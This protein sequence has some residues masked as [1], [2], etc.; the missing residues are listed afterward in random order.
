MSDNDFDIKRIIAN[1]KEEPYNKEYNLQDNV[2]LDEFQNPSIV[3][4]KGFE[5]LKSE[6][7]PYVSTGYPKQ[8]RDSFFDSKVLGIPFM[9]HNRSLLDHPNFES[10]T[11]GWFD[12]NVMGLV[13]K[14][15]VESDD[16]NTYLSDP[17]YNYMDDEQ[18]ENF[19]HNLDYFKYSTNEIRTK[20]LITKYKCNF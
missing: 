14:S 17:N 7:L 6:N 2:I 11:D 9:Y 19:Q 10:F 15:Q 1:I 8:E 20:Q 4:Q 5:Y 13:Y 16:P 3:D 18:L 12:E